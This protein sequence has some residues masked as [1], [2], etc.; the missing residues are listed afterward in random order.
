MK[1]RKIMGILITSALCVSALAGCGSSTNVSSSAA[2][3]TA[4]SSVS[5]EAENTSDEK[6]LR[7][8]FPSTL[9]SADVTNSTSATMLKET[10]GVAETLVYADSNFKL[11]PM[12][13]TEWEM[14]GDNTWVFKLR[15]NVT[16]HDGTP[17]N[18]KAVKWCIERSL[19]ENSE[20]A[21]TTYIQSVEVIDDHTV[22]FTT[23]ERTTDLP[24]AM[25]YVGTAIIA[26]SS[27]DKSGSFILPIGTGPFKAESFDETTGIFTAVRSDNYW[28]DINTSVTKR[29]VKSMPDASA[30][31]LAVQNG[32][33][34]IANDIPFSD[35]E[36][37]ENSNNTNVSKFNTARTYFYEY[38]MKKDLFKDERVRKALIYAINKNEI[39]NDVLFG[40]GGV[41]KGILMDNMPWAN[42]NVD[43][44]EYNPDKAKELLA[45]A[46]YKDTDNDGYLDKDGQKLTV[47]IITFTKRPGCPLI[48][49]ATQGY[50]ANI[51]IDASVKVMDWSAMNELIKKGDFDIALN[52]ATSAYVPTPAYYLDAYYVHNNIGYK[53]DKLNELVEKCK[54]T[55]KMDEKYEYSKEAQALGQ[56]D[57]CIY[58]PVLYGAVFAVSKNVTNFEFNA[59]AHDFIVP[60]NTDLK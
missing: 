48:A 33:I 16:F 60:Y 20:L 23:S 47:K 39:V 58:T 2:Y 41:P 17:F 56:E 36:T 42:T 34:D 55:D 8:A 50:F 4:S 45:E 5:T 53:N 15:D 44:Y 12:L 46:G 7:I 37:L 21:G 52:S 13:A 10:A 1:F 40:V 49:Q 54:A 24:A 14:T 31:S 28:G 19:K 11:Q 29:I 9:T 18:A 51:G 38:N 30:R 22:Q 59:A 35:L 27:V 26:P 57:A 25:S 3:S 43:T 6:V 32:E